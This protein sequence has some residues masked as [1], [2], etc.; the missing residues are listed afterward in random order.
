MGGGGIILP[1]LAPPLPSSM[2][3]NGRHQQ[4]DRSPNEKETPVTLPTVGRSPIKTIS[5]SLGPFMKDESVAM[6]QHRQ[7]G[8]RI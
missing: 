6:G 4:T 2:R 1:L 5:E 7:L 3:N 8:L